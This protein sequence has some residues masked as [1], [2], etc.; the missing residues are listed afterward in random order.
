MGLDI[1]KP[2]GFLFLLLGLIL[3]VYGLTGG[4]AQYARSNGHNINLCW[5]AVM[6]IAGAIFLY[7]ARSSRAS[8]TK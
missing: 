8:H 4:P 2:I 7:A 5:G 3:A 6:A 1:R